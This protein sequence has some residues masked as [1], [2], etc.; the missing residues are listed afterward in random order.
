MIQSV[1]LAEDNLE[2]CFFF[3]R[4]LSEVAPQTSIFQV[5][6]G[7]A[8]LS[9][10]GSF[11]PDLLF[12]DLNMPCKDG[13]QCIKEI[14]ENKACHRLPIVVFTVSS[15]NNAIQTAYGFGANL[16]I[17]KPNEYSRLVSTLRSILSMNWN[18]PKTITQK[19][20]Y[21]SRYVPFTA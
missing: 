15:Q 16:Y 7:D 12:L 9:L 10:L 6:D 2:H 11:L 8:L 17:V 18:D 21:G 13:V 4:A 14:R 20:F 19:H 5:H 1:L 3:K